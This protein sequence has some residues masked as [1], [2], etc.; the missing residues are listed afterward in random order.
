M[1]SPEQSEWAPPPGLTDIRDYEIELFKKMQAVDS[2]LARHQQRRIELL[3]AQ[4]IKT[5]VN[6]ISL[7]PS[8]FPSISGSAVRRG[9]V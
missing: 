8:T 1:R 5:V 6:W 3:E 4:G 9:I 2:E 7:N